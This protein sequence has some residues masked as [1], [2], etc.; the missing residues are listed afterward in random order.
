MKYLLVISLFFSI[1]GS[2]IS[3]V[4]F[5]KG[6]IKSK[7]NIKF[8]MPKSMDKLQKLKS[9]INNKKN[10]SKRSLELD[11]IIDNKTAQVQIIKFYNYTIKEKEKTIT[12][13]TYF[14]FLKKHI[15]KTI[16]FNVL[17]TFVNSSEETVDTKCDLSN[18]NWYNI[19]GDGYITSY[20]C[21]AIINKEDVNK[22]K[23]VNISTSK[24]MKL[25]YNETHQDDMNFKDI[26]FNGNSS[27]ESENLQNIAK[28]SELVELTEAQFVS[29][30]GSYFIIN[31]TLDQPGVLKQ[32]EKFNMSFINIINGNKECK[33]YTC[34]VYIKPKNNRQID[35]KCDTNDNSI[36]TTI[37]DL[38]LSSG[39][40]SESNALVIKMKNSSQMTT[41][42]LPIRDEENI[43]ANS[44][45]IDVNENA[46]LS[47]NLKFIE[48]K[49]AGIQF[50]KF[51]NY[52][53]DEEKRIIKF[54][55]YFYF[56]KKKIP[57]EIIFRLR[58]VY[59]N[60]KRR[61]DLAESIK[62]TCSINDDS[63]VGKIGNGVILNYTCIAEPNKE[64]DKIVNVSI[65]S[66]IPMIFGN[67]IG[68]YE[69]LNY[70][71]INF[72]GDSKEESS[73]LNQIKN[74]TKKVELKKSQI[75]SI[76]RNYL[77]IQGLDEEGIMKNDDIYKMK[78]RN[79]IEDYD[80]KFIEYNCIVSKNF[81]TTTELICDT[82]KNPMSTTLQDIH[83]SSGYYTNNDKI[84]LIIKMKNWQY[85]RK[86][87]S[88]ISASTRTNYRTSSSGLSG[89]AIT[90]IVFAC[91]AVIAG[92][93]VLI[94]V[95]RKT[96]KVPEGINNDSSINK[97]ESTEKL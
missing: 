49:Y 88:I 5:K 41:I 53:F 54:Q 52:S 19:I 13:N 55:T 79:K 26:N 35:L 6:T 30:D 92:T 78:F 8:K 21:S 39:V 51:Y 31:G 15:P 82:T 56:Y 69:I 46:S 11:K 7:F 50:A 62:S 84:L 60:N 67:N 94:L 37:K 77:K 70:T 76:S 81:D 97:Y 22:I 95:F 63:L 58:V 64:I 20:K 18:K 44:D 68:G 10:P 90:G 89:G 34:Y 93:I 3:D 29:F 17:I 80:D 59:S 83:L 87:D 1:F 16:N 38:N 27:K 40:S 61:L 57:K 66:D 24:P 42:E 47:D 14:Y 85:D 9:H 12:F 75:V 91:A 71:D 4:A 43:A 33:S 74:I 36:N 45:P 86:I 65:N 32:D 73:N 96:N 28:V 72:N 48:N 25:I 2:I 23:N